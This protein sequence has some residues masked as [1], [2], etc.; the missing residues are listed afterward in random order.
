MA[1]FEGQPF[2]PLSVVLGREVEHRLGQGETCF[3]INLPM[4][5]REVRTD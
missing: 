2:V 4:D 3:R 5:R 1:P